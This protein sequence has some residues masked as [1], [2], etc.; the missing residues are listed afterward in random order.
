MSCMLLS[1]IAHPPFS[2]QKRSP[3]FGGHGLLVNRY[4][5]SSEL[6]GRYVPQR[7]RLLDRGKGAQSKMI[8]HLWGTPR[9]GRRASIEVVCLA[10]IS[11]NVPLFLSRQS[12]FGSLIPSRFPLIT[13]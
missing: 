5:A 1:L 7:P 2:A 6:L 11:T 8:I 13:E 3:I 10:C 9:C 4:A 12:S